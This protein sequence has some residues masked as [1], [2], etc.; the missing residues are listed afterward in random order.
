MAG[1]SFR[2]SVVGFQSFPAAF[3]V[4]DM[5]HTKSTPKD[6]TAHFEMFAPRKGPIYAPREPRQ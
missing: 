5:A 4:T 6:S 1:F 2:I 3:S